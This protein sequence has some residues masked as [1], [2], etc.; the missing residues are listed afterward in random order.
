MKPLRKGGV[1]HEKMLLI[2]PRKRKVRY[3]DMSDIINEE[4]RKRKNKWFLDS[5]PWISFEDVEQIIRVHIYQ[6]F[7][8]WCQTYRYGMPS[9]DQK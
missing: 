2:M 1:D 4:I 9:L 3:E 8:Q 5:V 6:K 7:D